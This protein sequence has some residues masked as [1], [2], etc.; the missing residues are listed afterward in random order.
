MLLISSLIFVSNC[1]TIP[2]VPICAEVTLSKGICAYT[3]TNKT[4]TVDDD[5]PLEGQTWFDMRA[6]VL[7]VPAGSWGQ[8]KAWMIKMCKKNKCDVDISS[9]DRDISK[10]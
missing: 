7:S 6:K 8:I 4:V 10:E 1:A 5:H 2:D 3:V 9:W